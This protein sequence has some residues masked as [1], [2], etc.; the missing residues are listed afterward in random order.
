MSQARRRGTFEERKAQAIQREQLRLAVIEATRRERYQQECKAYDI[1]VWWQHDMS[2]Q[3][4]DRIVNRRTTTQM[5]LAQ[6]FGIWPMELLV[7]EV[8]YANHKPHSRP[9]RRTTT[10][11]Q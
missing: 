9:H 7:D 5:Q 6:I 10:Q 8:Y 2:K 4:C 1:M 3:R 11:M